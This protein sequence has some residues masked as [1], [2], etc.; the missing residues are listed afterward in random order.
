MW[1]LLTFAV[2]LWVLMPRKALAY[3]NGEPFEIELKEIGNGASMRADAADA[4]NDMAEA[5]AE[6][7]GLNLQC[8]GP[9]SGF[10]TLQE[11]ID[12]R[13]QVGAYGDGSGGLAAKAGY[14]PHQSGLAVDISGLDPSNSNFNSALR[15]WM[16]E[17]A[18]DFGF[19]NA[20]AAY[21]TTKEFW[22]WEYKP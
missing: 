10:R 17:R 14:S 19:V 21:V 9:R 3:V 15:G 6:E 8:S 13:S 1:P 12:L 11:Q 2:V 16:N 20:G 18:G 5:C 4:F 22:H 7:T